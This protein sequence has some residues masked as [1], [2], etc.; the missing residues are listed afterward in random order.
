MTVP[1]RVVYAFGAVRSDAA[2]EAGLAHVDCATEGL[3]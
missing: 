3:D 2:D 1:S